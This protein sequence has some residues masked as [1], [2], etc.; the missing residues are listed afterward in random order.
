M[1]EVAG[2]VRSRASISPSGELAVLR[3]EPL[4]VEAHVCRRLGRRVW[5]PFLDDLARRRLHRLAPS[6]RHLLWVTAL[7]SL[8][9]VEHDG[10]VVGEGAHAA[11]YLPF[12][13]GSMGP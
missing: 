13:D 9:L 8:K 1:G 2:R 3:L 7:D 11:L 10:C 4:E 5:L 6:R 12:R